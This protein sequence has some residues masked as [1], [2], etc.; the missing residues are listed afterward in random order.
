MFH[1]KPD[2]KTIE[3]ANAD[4]RIGGVHDVAFWR[5]FYQLLEESQVQ[6]PAVICDIISDHFWDLFDY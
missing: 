1:M 5:D 4:I 3:A 6:P 2:Q